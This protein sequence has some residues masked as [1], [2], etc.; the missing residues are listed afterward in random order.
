MFHTYFASVY[1]RCCIC[2]AMVFNCF[3]V[4]FASVSDACFKCCIC[5]KTYV[6]SVASGY[7]K[8]RFGIP[9]VTMW[10]TCRSPCCCWGRCSGSPCGCLRPADVSIARI[11]RQGE[12]GATG[13]SYQLWRYGVQTLFCY[14]DMMGRAS[15]G[16]GRDGAWWMR[17][18]GSMS[19]RLLWPDVGKLVLPKLKS[20][21][22]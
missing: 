8:S 16:T 18:N 22:K 13:R 3:Q 15:V 20:R 19:E 6:A 2:F 11:H 7:F 17:A 4:C 5:L 21:P 14:G 12:A 9:H 10:P 1:P